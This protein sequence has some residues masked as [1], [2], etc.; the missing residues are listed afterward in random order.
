VTGIILAGCGFSPVLFNAVSELIINPNN[1]E[2]VK[3]TY[4][5]DIAN[6][7]KIYYIFVICVLGFMF[8]ISALFMFPYEEEIDGQEPALEVFLYII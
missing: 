2:A 4:P 8:I 3:N 5:Q 7:V 6:N 1:V